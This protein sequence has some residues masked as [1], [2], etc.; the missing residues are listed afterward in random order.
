MSPSFDEELFQD[1]VRR[2]CA[3]DRAAFVAKR[4]LVRE[5][6][7]G[8]LSFPKDHQPIAGDLKDLQMYADLLEEYY[9]LRGT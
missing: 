6:G 7:G 9:T 4:T 8:D 2:C 5:A 1:V 3:S